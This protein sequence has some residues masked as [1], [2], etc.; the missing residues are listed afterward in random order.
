MEDRGPADGKPATDGKM[1]VAWHMKD[2]AG[3]LQQHAQDAFGDVGDHAQ[4]LAGEVAHH[5]QQDAVEVR[6]EIPVLTEHVRDTVIDPF[7][8]GRHNASRK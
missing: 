6:R 1:N 4:G 5:S 3:E 7:G 2:M 8:N